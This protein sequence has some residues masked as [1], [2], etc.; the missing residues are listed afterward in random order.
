MVCWTKLLLNL[1][2]MVYKIIYVQD[3]YIFYLKFTNSTNLYRSYYRYMVQ[4][5]TCNTTW[6]PNNFTF[7]F[8]SKKYRSLCRPFLNTYRYTAKHIYKR[9]SSIYKYNWKPATMQRLSFRGLLC[10]SALPSVQNTERVANLCMVYSVCLPFPLS[11]TL[12]E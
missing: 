8:V 7:R 5:R 11:K 10:M 12:R 9:L 1:L 6:P 3:V 2:G 4:H